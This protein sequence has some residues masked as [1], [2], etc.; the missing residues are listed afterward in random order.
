[1]LI[2]CVSIFYDYN[3]AS[4]K[5]RWI[6]RHLQPF[7]L[8]MPQGIRNRTPALL[9]FKVINPRAITLASQK[10]KENV[11]FRKTKK[12]KTCFFF[13]NSG[14]QQSFRLSFFNDCYSKEC[15]DLRDY[16]LNKRGTVFSWM[17]RLRKFVTLYS[18]WTVQIVDMTLILHA[19]AQN[20]KK[21]QQ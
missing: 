7:P 3:F 6:L 13:Q 2:L 9:G 20:T 11:R 15:C 1:M 8:S 10:R 4:S 16:T 19:I 17:S 5:A 14:V 21:K 18:G 12:K